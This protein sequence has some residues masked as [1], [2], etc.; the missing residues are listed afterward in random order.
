MHQIKR[1]Q[2]LD[3][4]TFNDVTT[5]EQRL[6][7]TSQMVLNFQQLNARYLCGGGALSNLKSISWLDIWK[8]IAGASNNPS[9]GQLMKQMDGFV[10]ATSLLTT[11]QVTPDVLVSASNHLLNFESS[12]LKGLR[13]KDSW[14]G[15]HH[16]QR[17]KMY[18]VEHQFVPSLLNEL[19]VFLEQQALKSNGLSMEATIVA[20]RQFLNIHPFP[21]GNGRLGRALWQ[22]IAQK[23]NTQLLSPFLYRL[24]QNGRHDYGS[25]QS[26]QT[27]ECCDVI[28]HHFWKNAVSWQ[29]QVQENI[30]GLVKNA[31]NKQN[32]TIALRNLSKTEMKLLEILW[33]QPVLSHSYVAK[34][35]SISI[36]EAIDAINSL[37]VLGLLKRLETKSIDAEA[38]LFVDT[39]SVQLWLAIEKLIFTL[40]L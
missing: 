2:C 36:L 14:R 33:N 16:D 19:C 26:I 15:G 29:R 31:I 34:T 38:L 40:R 8:S 4:S 22:A 25:F 27:K 17:E 5:L 35:M 9:A 23:S 37:C 11:T 18:F 13:N 12:R 21:E 6:A 10:K 30:D 7:S 1:N 3:L 39:E 20:H 28:S 24:I 32:S